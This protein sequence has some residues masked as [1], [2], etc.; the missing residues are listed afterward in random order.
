[1]LA[2][3]LGQNETFLGEI[4]QSVGQDLRDVMNS[5]DQI[6]RDIFGEGMD[7]LFRRPERAR[8][9][10]TARRVPAQPTRMIAEGAIEAEIVDEGTTPS[11]AARL[12]G[13]NAVD[14]LEAEVVAES[15]DAGA[16]II[17]E[18]SAGV[19]VAARLP[20]P[21]PNF[22]AVAAEATAEM[23]TRYRTNIADRQAASNQ[24]IAARQAASDQ[25][26]AARRAASDQRIAARQ[27]NVD[28]SVADQR[29]ELDA[30]I[31]ERRS[32]FDQAVADRHAEFEQE[33]E[34]RRRGASPPAPGK[35]GQR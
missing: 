28:R 31:V 20:R 5:N 34:D 10:V 13:P 25:R 9:T 7:T 30:E 3:I 17:R 33:I 1:M 24:R 16:Q 23:R 11:G 35:N 32:S 27:P 22:A 21:I 29:A 15:V 8:G 6:F 12:L 2:D 4:G 18:T 14:V 19:R 26:I